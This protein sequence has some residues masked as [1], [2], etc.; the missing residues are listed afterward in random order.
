MSNERSNKR[1][2]VELVYLRDG[3][4]SYIVENPNYKQNMRQGPKEEVLFL[5]FSI[6][7]RDGHIF[8][9][10]EWLAIEKGIDNLLKD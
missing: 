2:E 3:P 4:K 7:E 8:T 5:P 1:I 9:M 6:V 10:P